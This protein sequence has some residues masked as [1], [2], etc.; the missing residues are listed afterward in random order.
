MNDVPASGDSIKALQEDYR[1]QLE[2]FYAGLKLAPPYDSVEKAIK[3]LVRTLTTMTIEERAHLLSN[4]ESMWTHYRQAFVD[5][6]LHFKHRGIILG[7]IRD[8]K[9]TALP[10][11]H[12]AF[13]DVYGLSHR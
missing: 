6:G 13:L 1:R 2:T 10:P 7:L 8:K 11:E 5:A 3:A 9:T 4:A 12:A